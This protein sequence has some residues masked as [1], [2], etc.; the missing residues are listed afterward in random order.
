[1]AKKTPAQ[2]DRE[3]NKALSASPVDDI[4]D[5]ATGSAALA[6]FMA[7]NDVELK[8]SWSTL[9]NAMIELQKRAQ[10]GEDTGQ[11]VSWLAELLRYPWL[12]KLCGV[13]ATVLAWVC[14]YP[15]FGIS[16]LQVDAPGVRRAR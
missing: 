5:D 16:Q 12:S 4:I 11:L 8:I 2:L 14:K 10:R 3:I 1:M 13:G 6:T 15:G 9:K 7:A